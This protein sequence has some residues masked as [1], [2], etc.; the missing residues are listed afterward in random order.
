MKYFLKAFYRKFFLSS[1]VKKLLTSLLLMEI[2]VGGRELALPITVIVYGTHIA[3]LIS[4]QNRSRKY[5]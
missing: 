3:Y 2:F 5:S 4:T 1:S